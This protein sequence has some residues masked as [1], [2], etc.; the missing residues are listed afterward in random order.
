MFIG[1]NIYNTRSP[2]VMDLW[3]CIESL[4]A[5]LFSLEVWEVLECPSGARASG[6]E[7]AGG[8][9]VGDSSTKGGRSGCWYWR[10]HLRRLVNPWNPALCLRVPLCCA[11]AAA[12]AAHL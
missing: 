2:Y 8:I 11:A 9:G 12:A 1:F 4:G 5:G 10:V 7:E 6:V 3:F